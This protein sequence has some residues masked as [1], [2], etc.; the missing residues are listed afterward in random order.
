MLY[1]I[2]TLSC[3]NCAWWNLAELERRIKIYNKILL[4]W[5]TIQWTRSWVLTPMCLFSFMLIWM[6]S[7]QNLVS[8]AC[9]QV[10]VS[11]RGI[12]F[13]RQQLDERPDCA[14]ISYMQTITQDKTYIAMCKVEYSWMSEGVLL[15]L[16]KWP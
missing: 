8:S 7:C 3:N 11:I 16:A 2:A 15:I 1:I 13:Q 10:V 4:A 14:C 5:E 9:W 6:L 12:L